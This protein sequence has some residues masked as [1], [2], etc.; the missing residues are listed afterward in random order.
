VVESPPFNITCCDA[1]SLQVTELSEAARDF[2]LCG[3]SCAGTVASR[4]PPN[5]L[6]ARRELTREFR[7]ETCCSDHRAIATWP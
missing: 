5:E 2:W 4:R 3:Y 6:D 7:I 1:L